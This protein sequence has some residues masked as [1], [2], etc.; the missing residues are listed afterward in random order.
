MK[1]F[2]D[3]KYCEV[4]DYLDTKVPY[5]YADYFNSCLAGGVAQGKEITENKIMK[6]LLNGVEDE[7]IS[8]NQALGLNKVYVGMIDKLNCM[9]G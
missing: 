5:K 3:E 8:Y 1:K 7:F 6:L 4:L 2:D 9:R